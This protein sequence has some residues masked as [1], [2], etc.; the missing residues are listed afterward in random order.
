MTNEILDSVRPNPE[1]NNY[2]LIKGKILEFSR[3]SEAF[4][5]EFRKVVDKS[6]TLRNLIGRLDSNEK[7]VRTYLY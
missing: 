6:T 3:N 7:D 4:N 5:R 1:N 2:R